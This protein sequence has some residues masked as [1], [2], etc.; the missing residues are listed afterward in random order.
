MT[1]IQ[2]LYPNIYKGID[3][4]SPQVKEE[5]LD[6]CTDLFKAFGLII[7]RQ[8]GLINKDQLMRVINTQLT[9]GATPSLR[10]RASYAMGAFAVILNQQQLNQLCQLLLTKIKSNTNKADT[11]T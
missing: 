9:T 8:Q 6:I 10:K 3:K 1:L 11:V 7:L 4:G 5:C 2:T